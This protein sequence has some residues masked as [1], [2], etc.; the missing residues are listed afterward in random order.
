MQQMFAW[1][2]RPHTTAKAGSAVPPTE[3]APQVRGRIRRSAAYGLLAVVW[4]AAAAAVTEPLLAQ[5]ATGKPSIK[6][7]LQVGRKLTA[8]EG[9]IGDPDGRHGWGHS[10][11]TFQWVRVDGETRTDISGATDST[12]TV[13]EA[14]RDKKIRVRV[15]FDDKKGNA[16]SLKS[17]ISAKVLRKQHDC[18]TDRAGDD[19]C[20]L[21]SPLDMALTRWEDGMQMQ[22]GKYRRYEAVGRHGR[23]YL[24]DRDIVYRDTIS[25]VGEIG[26]FYYDDRR[27]RI[28]FQITYGWLPDGTIL[29]LGGR[30][31]R[32]SDAIVDSDIPG[33][34]EWNRP[35]DYNWREGQFVTVSA[36]IR[37]ALLTVRDAE[38]TEGEDESLDFAVTLSLPANDTV[39]VEYATSDGTATAG[40]DY[41]AVSNTLTFLP[42]Q[43]RKTISVPI[44]DD[45]VEDDGETMNLRLSNPSGAEFADNR[46]KGTIRNT[47]GGGGESAA[48]S[49]KAEWQQVPGSHNGTD[50][51]VVQL[52]FS[53]DI[54][55]SFRV[56]R[57]TAISAANGTVQTVKR[58]NDRSDLWRV[59]VEPSGDGD[60]TLSIG[61]SP[62]DCTAEDAVCTS[63]D[64]HLSNMATASIPGP[65]EDPADVLTAEFKQVPASHNGTD[66]IVVQ[67]EFSEA[68][69]TS[70]RVLRD[71]AISAANG[72]VR[73]VKRVDGQ[74]DLWKVHVEPSGDG[75]VTLS[76]GP[77][78][79]DCTAEDAVCTSDD[80]HLSNMATASIPGPS[81]APADT[82]TAEFKQVPASHNGTNTFT[83][84]IALSQDIASGTKPKFWKALTRSGANLKQ[85][86]RV[87]NRLDLFEVKLEPKG[88][89][90]VVISLGP[91]PSDCTA[92]DAVCTS[93]GTALSN[94]ETDTIV[95]VA[96]FVAGGGDGEDAALAVAGGLTP[97]EAAAALFGDRSLSENRMEALD[98][99]GNRNGSYDLG[100]LLSWIDRCRSGDADCGGTATD[101]G[102]V[103][104]AALPAAAGAAGTSGRT[105]GRAPGRRDRRPARRT[106]R[107]R[108][109]PGYGLMMLL[110]ATMTW[111]CADEVVGP[112]IAEPDPGLLTIELAAPPAN[113]DIGVLLELEGPG[114]GAV[115]APGFELYESGAA[116]RHQ[117]VVAG[118]LRS[119]PLAQF[120]VPD[121]NQL[122]LY[123]VHILQVTGEDYGLRDVAE[124]EAAVAYDARR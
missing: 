25:R 120:E 11:Y 119:G 17:R 28:R 45:A 66:T 73:V 51:I 24:G 55:T 16:E 1:T 18:A 96:P 111:S 65:S 39:T 23:G 19:W 108:S 106:R 87:N 47:E 77:S 76:I 83:F 42:G 3:S 56:L 12:Y 7:V 27:D 97:D 69:A 105:G 84:R 109:T 60:V 101:F 34:Y 62:T 43:R 32:V 102:P 63:D 59:L 21:L 31:F 61:P 110:A 121:R 88:T 75:D 72:T 86:R 33:K 100:D 95:Y 93:G 92:E 30:A 64:L 20:T 117:I 49:L 81:E 70:Y 14:D 118:S 46:A 9:T 99:L 37:Y 114:V 48:D 29:N 54:E 2:Q 122:H 67:L 4:I 123:R 13:V 15:D 112:A 115:R 116:E 89:D 6:G 36:K 38:A 10:T 71:T 103:G 85:I 98:R 94:A 5:N 82:L 58:V 124:Y 79:T 113:R 22:Y 40:E 57:D 90:D 44:V 8:E 35:S 107:R 91:S 52:N 41:T 74:S 78:P 53:E 80:L 50:S 26:I 68:I 104:G